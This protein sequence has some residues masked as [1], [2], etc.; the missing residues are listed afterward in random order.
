MKGVEGR[1]GKRR[2]IGRREKVKG[3]EGEGWRGRKEKWSLDLFQ[4]AI[5]W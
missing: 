5:G 1:R 3:G 2:S 4:Q